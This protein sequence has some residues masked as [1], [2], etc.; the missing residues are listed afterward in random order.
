M[1]I[2]EFFLL[3]V[4]DSPFASVLVIKFL[5]GVDVLTSLVC[6][7]AEN[8]NISVIHSA[9]AVVVP[10]SIKIGDLEPQIDITVVHLT[11]ELRL[12]FLF[13]GPSYNDE[14][15]AKPAAGMTMSWMLHLVSLH[16][17]HVLVWEDLDEIVQRL[18]ILLVIATSDEV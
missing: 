12:V 3:D 1:S 9:G 5:D 17:L 18:V 15:L 2:W 13:S 4:D 6:D 8:E 7:T 14:F 16:K 11:F 10:A